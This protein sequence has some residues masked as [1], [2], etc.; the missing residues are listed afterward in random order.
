MSGIA[1]RLFD[2]KLRP[3]VE[4]TTAANPYPRQGRGRFGFGPGS[5]DDVPPSAD[6]S[7]S[8]S[9]IADTMRQ[10]GP[11]K[12][13]SSIDE[14][15]DELEK[16]NKVELQQPDE[17]ATLLDRLNERVQE[18]ALRGEKAPNIDLCGVSVRGTNLFCGDSKGLR[19]AEMPQLTGEP[20]PGSWADLNLTKNDAGR[21][22]AGD[23]FREHIAA[24][25]TV[26]DMSIPADRLRA[27]QRELNGQSVARMKRDIDSGAFT[28][29]PVFISSD[30]YVLDGHHGW[31]ATVGSDAA[32]NV[33]GEL[34]MSAIKV[35]MPILELL[36]EADQFGADIGL[37][38]VGITSDDGRFAAALGLH[39]AANP[40]PRQE[41]G[42]FGF[43]PGGTVEERQHGDGVEF[44]DGLT[45][46]EIE[47][48]EA[49][50]SMDGDRFSVEAKVERW[51][52]GNDAMVT[53]YVYDAEGN[54]IGMFSR[55]LRP[56]GKRLGSTVPT[57]ENR[58]FMLDEG[59]QGQGIGTEI[60]EHQESYWASH[61]FEQMTVKA[62]VDVGGYAWARAGYQWDTKLTT[63]RKV[64][65]MLNSARNWA[66]VADRGDV[67]ETADEMMG[68]LGDDRTWPSP[69]E[70]SELGRR[71]G[72]TDWPGRK[73]MLGA[74]WNGVKPIGEAVTAAAVL[75]PADLG[76][77][78]AGW[79]KAWA[80]R[81][82]A[83]TRS[84]PDASVWHVD[85][86]ATAEALADFD[87]RLDEA[88]GIEGTTAA[89]R[90]D[91]T[92]TRSA[93]AAALDILE[94]EAVSVVM[95]ELR[96]IVARVVDEMM[97]G[98]LRFL[99]TTAASLDVLTSIVSEWAGAI[100][101]RV[102]PYYREVYMLG[103][104]SALT[105]MIEMGHDPIE[106][107]ADTGDIPDFVRAVQQPYM[108]EA[109]AQHL[110]LARD[111]FLHLGDQA[112][113][114]ARQVMLDGLDHGRPIDEIA[115]ELSEVTGIAEAHATTI[116]RTEVISAA[117]AG[118]FEQARQAGQEKPLYKQWLATMDDRVRPTHEEADGQVVPFDDPFIVGGAFMRYPGDPGGPNEE[119]LRCRCTILFTDDP[120]GFDVKGAKG[121]AEG[122]V[123]DDVAHPEQMDPL[124]QLPPE[125][126][127]VGDELRKFRALA[128]PGDPRI[129]D[130]DPS[131]EL[132]AYEQARERVGEAIDDAIMAW[133]NEKPRLRMKLNTQGMT[134]TVAPEPYQLRMR[135]ILDAIGQP[136]GG[137]SLDIRRPG[138]FGALEE[139]VYEAAQKN[140]PRSW[141]RHMNMRKLEAVEL[142]FNGQAYYTPSTRS[143]Y[144]PRAD[145]PNA[146]LRV[147]THELMHHAGHTVPGL[148]RAEWVQKWQRETV[149][150]Q[151]MV[152]GKVVKTREWETPRQ[153]YQGQWVRE[154]LYPTPYMGRDYF[155]DRPPPGST[156]GDWE[157]RYGLR[158]EASNSA[159]LW[160]AGSEA[161]L[162]T[163]GGMG[164]TWGGW[165][166]YHDETLQHLGL[167]R[168]VLG[169]LATIR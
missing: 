59:M 88:M 55:T 167:R 14:A 132:L 3:V 76:R 150:R 105:R 11:A 1:E 80:D 64:R 97:G 164:A 122:G 149:M 142:D 70:L 82:P 138:Q 53:G 56:G 74:E 112:W 31:A 134:Y 133:A 16:G 148:Q 27:T 99:S 87:R 158:W 78:H 84:S 123:L 130:L 155:P 108:Q 119:V 137:A 147:A 169:V 107:M 66:I 156:P 37:P 25:T 141:L 23:A 49:G 54:E 2:M 50:L 45:D 36:A 46:E 30:N 139:L 4:G 110:A 18:A 115:E 71:P 143:I 60:F 29:K 106:F 159:E 157:R 104:A 24:K 127:E 73:A 160:T 109:A 61:G 153:R 125:L 65:D 21:V 92:P 118:A 38:R 161:F 146:N 135:Q 47:A 163:P 41:G 12:R 128:D 6:P 120:D 131:P 98:D 96:P 67:V 77:V 10:S 79:A 57:V 13:V 90:A 166:P 43:A 100:D 85:E 33:L 116:A 117:N 86:G 26:R 19:R 40:H 102:L 35:D 63:T 93:L 154:D 69:F 136:L 48:V 8:S 7:L 22:N 126:R 162:T 114:D 58:S 152:N 44:S 20:R 95:G 144:L 62:N 94:Y 75:G 34:N 5:R 140:T 68:N 124:D 129:G 32:N 103:G 121:R 101:E 42:R 51:G 91:S 17:V 15:L 151:S 168:W 89:T 39:Y 81:I 113:K 72:D 165:Q 28:P 145:S 111:R 83:A 52:T 9:G